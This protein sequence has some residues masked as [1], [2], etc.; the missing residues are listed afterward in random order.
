MQTKLNGRI[1]YRSTNQNFVESFPL[2]RADDK[3]HSICEYSVRIKKRSKR[4]DVSSN[5]TKIKINLITFKEILV[6]NRIIKEHYIRRE[7]L[8]FY[9]FVAAT[10][11]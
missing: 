11:L 8:L 9:T 7:K 4:E 6:S 3:L 2:F 10:P 1:K 5:K